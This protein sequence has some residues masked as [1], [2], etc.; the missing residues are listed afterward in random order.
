LVLLG[1]V[2][3]PAAPRALI[4]PAA[5]GPTE[6]VKVGDQ[7]GGEKVVEIRKDGIIV[8]VEGNPVTVPLP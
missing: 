8:E 3:D 2:Y 5:G 4:R 6:V 7:V 1:V